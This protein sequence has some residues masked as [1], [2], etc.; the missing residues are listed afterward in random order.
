MI[1]IFSFYSGLFDCFNC[2]I[3]LFQRPDWARIISTNVM[4]LGVGLLV[5]LNIGN[6]LKLQL[7]SFMQ[8]CFVPLA[9]H[10]LSTSTLK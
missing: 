9:G 4:N 5:F 1:Y 6:S 8:F 3:C 7:A 2:H 10:K